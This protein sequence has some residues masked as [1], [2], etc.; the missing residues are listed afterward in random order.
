MTGLFYHIQAPF[1]TAKYENQTE[2]AVSR[3][4]SKAR[5]FISRL[6]PIHKTY[7]QLS[8]LVK[9]RSLLMPMPKYAAASSKVRFAFSQ[10]GTSY[11]NQQH[12]PFQNIFL[13]LFFSCISFPSKIDCEW[14]STCTRCTM[15]TGLVHLVRIVHVLLSL[16]LFFQKPNAPK[17]SGKASVTYGDFVGVFQII[18]T[19]VLL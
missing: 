11:F 15:R 13:F 1:S 16:L 12:R 7:G 10:M 6:E 5:R 18:L 2:N 17:A 3:Y 14:K 8:L 4:R 9:S 19:A